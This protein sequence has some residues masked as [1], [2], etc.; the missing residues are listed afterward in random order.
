MKF[1]KY[2]YREFAKHKKNELFHDSNHLE[3]Y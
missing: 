3:S 2:N 1:D